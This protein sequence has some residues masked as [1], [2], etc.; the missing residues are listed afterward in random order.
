MVQPSTTG[1]PLDERRTSYGYDASGNQDTRT[2][3]GVESGAAFGG[4]WT[5]NPTARGKAL[6]TPG[7]APRGRVPG[8]VMRTPTS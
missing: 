8:V 2:I 3:E 4:G 6:R 1:N 5:G 7:N